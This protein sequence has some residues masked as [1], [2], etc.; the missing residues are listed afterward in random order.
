MNQEYYVDGGGGEYHYLSEKVMKWYVRDFKS[1]ITV[2]YEKIINE[3]YPMFETIDHFVFH[4]SFIYLIINSFR[5]R[6]LNRIPKEYIKRMN[7]L[8]VCA[9]KK[10]LV[11]QQSAGILIS[12]PKTISPLLTKFMLEGGWEEKREL[13]E[14][15]IDTEYIVSERCRHGIIIKRGNECFYCNG[16]KPESYDKPGSENVVQQ[17]ER[18]GR[19]LTFFWG[20]DDGRYNIDHSQY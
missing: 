19:V 13:V 10:G 3:N 12:N 2:E 4:Y 8:L 20:N 1:L 11:F 9:K 7:H 15:P 5:N 14:D 6:P 18:A 16:G 17:M